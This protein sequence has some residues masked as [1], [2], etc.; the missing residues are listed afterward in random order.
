MLFLMY[1]TIYLY[2]F[3]PLY[4]NIFIFIVR[5]IYIYIVHYKVY[6]F[7]LP[8]VHYIYIY[9]VHYKINFMFFPFDFPYCRQ[10]FLEDLKDIVAKQFSIINVPLLV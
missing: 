1:I 2:L 7:I 8:I 9:I 4:N 5:Y 3:C 6:I 10:F